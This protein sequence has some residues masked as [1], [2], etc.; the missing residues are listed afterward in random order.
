[1]TQGSKSL[2]S[3]SNFHSNRCQAFPPAITLHL[4]LII[5]VI[6]KCAALSIHSP[7]VCR[8]AV[9]NP[10]TNPFT[11]TGFGLEDDTEKMRVTQFHYWFDNAQL[12]PKSISH[13]ASRNSRSHNTINYSQG[14]QVHSDKTE[15]LVISICSCF[16]RQIERSE[17]MKILR[18]RKKKSTLFTENVYFFLW[19]FALLL[20][21]KFMVLCLIKNSSKRRSRL[22]TGNMCFWSFSTVVYGPKP[23]YKNVHGIF[24][25]T[26]DWDFFFL[27]FNVWLVEECVVRCSEN[28]EICASDLTAHDCLGLHV[29]S[30][31]VMDE[32]NH[33]F[34]EVFRNLNVHRTHKSDRSVPCRIRNKFPNWIS[35]HSSTGY[36]V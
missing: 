36:F 25:S 32:V 30:F 28:I 31:S 3:L 1:M 6:R 21:V 16:R 23:L 8:R 11:A 18:H 2:T 4:F 20:R 24:I 29:V 17:R 33:L 26:D 15:N 9:Q 27:T 35:I 22:K 7:F 5:I 10:H 34:D 14:S 13:C 12:A 19:R